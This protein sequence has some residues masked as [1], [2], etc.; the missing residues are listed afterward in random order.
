M[1]VLSE[2]VRVEVVISLLQIMRSFLVAGASVGSPAIA[3]GAIK[4]AASTHLILGTAYSLAPQLRGS[5]KQSYASRETLMHF[6][7][8]QKQILI[9]RL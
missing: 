7:L 1:H 2:R 4:A 3:A 6:T 5:I 9:A 8:L